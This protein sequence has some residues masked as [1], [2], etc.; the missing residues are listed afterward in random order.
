VALFYSKLLKAERK[1]SIH[2]S[3]FSL[4]IL[5]EAETSN[6]RDDNSLGIA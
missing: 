3:K 4:T 2:E 6:A 1:L 5:G